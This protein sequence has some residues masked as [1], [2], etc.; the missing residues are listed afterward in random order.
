M[1]DIMREFTRATR[2]MKFYQI[3]YHDIVPPEQRVSYTQ[4]R[5]T[6]SRSRATSR[7]VS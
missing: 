7:G 1:G 4:S 6:R 5:S 2:E 3:R